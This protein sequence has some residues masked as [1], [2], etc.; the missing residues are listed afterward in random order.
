[1]LKLVIG[2][3]FLLFDNIKKLR[4][5][6]SV[7]QD[8]ELGMADKSAI[9]NPVD[10]VFRAGKTVWFMFGYIFAH[11]NLGNIQCTQSILFQHF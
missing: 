4:T 10:G 3:F 1:M 5:K 9:I 6:I 11:V 8:C 7:Q 2:A